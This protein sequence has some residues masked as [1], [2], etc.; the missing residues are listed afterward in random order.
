M[1]A[2]NLCLTATTLFWAFFA[3]ALLAVN[4]QE[5]A[6]E[7]SAQMAR[8]FS[9]AGGARSPSPPIPELHPSGLDVDL[10]IDAS[11]TELY[12]AYLAAFDKNHDESELPFRY[13]TFMATLARVETLNAAHGPCTLTG[14]VRSAVNFRYIVAYLSPNTPRRFS[15]ARL[16]PEQLL[17]LYRI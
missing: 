10:Y 8:R 12:E 9:A 1:S 13:S 15:A 3:V 7:S 4:R 16:R 5:A 14:K 6:S 2:I 11:G 17:R